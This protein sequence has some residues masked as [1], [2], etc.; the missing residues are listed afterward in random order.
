[1]LNNNSAMQ[2]RSPLHGSGR[3]LL[4]H[5]ALPLVDD[6]HALEWIRVMDNGRR[7]ISGFERNH[8][9]H[10]NVSVLTS[11]RKRTLPNAADFGA[12]SHE[13]LPVTRNAIVSKVPF[14]N[15]FKVTTLIENGEVH[16]S[17]HFLSHHLQLRSLAFAYRAPVNGEHFV[18]SFLSTDVSEAEEVECLRFTSLAL[19][20]VLP[21]VIT[22]LQHPSFHRVKFK[23]KLG[24]PISKRRMTSVRV[25]LESESH[26]KVVRIAN[27]NNLTLG[28]S[29]AP[30][31][32]PNVK[33][34]VKENVTEKWRDTASL[35]SAGICF[36]NNS[37][38]PDTGLEPLDDESHHAFVGNSLPEKLHKPLMRQRVKERLD[39]SIQNK[40]HTLS[41]DSGVDGVKRIVLTSSWPKPLRESDKICFVNHVQHHDRC[42]LHKLDFKNRNAYRPF[43]SVRFGYEHSPNGLCSVATTQELFRKLRDV[44]IERLAVRLPCYLIDSARSIAF[45]VVERNSQRCRVGNMVHETVELRPLIPLRSGTYSLERTLHTFPAL[46]PERVL[47]SRIHLGQR[48]FLHGFRNA[49]GARFVHPL[50]RYYD[51]VRLVVR[52]PHWFT[53]LDFPRRLVDV[54]SAKTHNISRFSRRK[55]PCMRGVS[56]LAGW[57]KHSPKRTAACCLPRSSTESASRTDSISRLNTQP[58]CSAVNASIARSHA[59]PH[60]S[61]LLSMASSSVFTITFN[62][63]PVYPGARRTHS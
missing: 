52:L 2:Q 16:S 45:E 36:L 11:S 5:P 3:A 15:R 47:L 50:R 31:L 22:K 17:T 18:T 61:R 33:R 56:D 8:A 57:P 13:R 40:V 20:S 42:K 25:C 29:C 28:L 7:K 14:Q 55:S 60:D 19:S 34:E 43:S 1:M 37:L 41:E 49:R 32:D 44:F 4:T 46:S 39:V 59:P 21:R 6:A 38:L 63:L 53:S 58:T 24:K 23:P 12:E 26:D 54:Q 27:N 30:V 62:F 10:R 48:P 9:R 51:A 35:R